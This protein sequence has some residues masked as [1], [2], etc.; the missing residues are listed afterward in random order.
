[1]QEARQMVS[2]CRRNMKEDSTITDLDQNK[3]VEDAKEALAAEVAWIKHY[4]SLMPRKAKSASKT[5][6]FMVLKAQATPYWST[7]SPNGAN[8]PSSRSISPPC[9]ISALV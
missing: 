7:A 8:Y 9:S 5:S 1:M 4:F 2:T 3:G 6:F